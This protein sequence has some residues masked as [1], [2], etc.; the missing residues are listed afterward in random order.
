MFGMICI[1]IQ[2]IHN[3]KEKENS[4]T[5]KRRPLKKAIMKKAPIINCKGP[6]TFPSIV[7]A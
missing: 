1:K 3:Y 7:I 6:V 5:L 4:I 2:L